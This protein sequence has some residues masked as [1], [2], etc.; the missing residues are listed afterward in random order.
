MGHYTLI[1]IYLKGNIWSS[2]KRGKI[3]ITEINS[4]KDVKYITTTDS[5]NATPTHM[6]IKYS[7]DMLNKMKGK[8]KLLIIITDGSPNYHQIVDGNSQRVNPNTYF[9]IVKKSYEEALK[10]TPNILF[11]V[12]TPYHWINERFANIFGVDRVVYVDQAKGVNEKVIHTNARRNYRG[13]RK[14]R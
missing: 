8:K 14:K 10:V 4:R 6:G 1:R 3:A 13:T 5:Y 11:V 7:I 9:P 2:N 12:I